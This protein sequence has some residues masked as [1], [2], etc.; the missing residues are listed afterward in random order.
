MKRWAYS[1]LLLALSAWTVPALEVKL[2]CPTVVVMSDGS[3]RTDPGFRAQDQT[4]DNRQR[5]AGMF[6]YTMPL[7]REPTQEPPVLT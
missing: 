3:A 7:T 5:C 4:E 1:L 2:V 6:H